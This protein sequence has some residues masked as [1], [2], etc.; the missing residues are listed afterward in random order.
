[1]G[2]KD[3]PPCLALMFFLGSK[4]NTW[5]LTSSTVNSFGIFIPNDASKPPPSPSS[6]MHLGGEHLEDSIGCGEAYS[7]F[8]G[9]CEVFWIS[10]FGPLSVARLCKTEKKRVGLCSGPFS[11]RVC[12]GRKRRIQNTQSREDNYLSLSPGKW[13][14]RSWLVL[15]WRV[16]EGIYQCFDGTSFLLGISPTEQE[17]EVIC[18]FRSRYLW[19]TPMAVSRQTVE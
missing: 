9:G 19:H 2:N 12:T 18:L 17:L 1:M 3:F 6:P 14:V 15:F 16:T 11:V 10:H 4:R 13:T 7:T 5:V 8:L